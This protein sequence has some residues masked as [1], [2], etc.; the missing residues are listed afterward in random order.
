[1]SSNKIIGATIWSSIQRFGGLAISFVSN[2][3]LARLLSPDDFGTMGLIMVFITVADVLVDGGL[4][5]ALIQKNEIEEKDETTIF[6]AN[7]VFSLFLFFAIFSAQ[8]KFSVASSRGANQRWCIHDTGR[9]GC[10]QC[11]AAVL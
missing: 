4:G 3:V 6:T 1:M 5:N 2:M 11:H 9:T 8:F 7:L 10:P